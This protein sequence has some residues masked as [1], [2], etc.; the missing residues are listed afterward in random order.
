MGEDDRG[1][2]GG[3]R[4]DEE[5]PRGT[6]GAV[7]GNSRGGEEG[8][9]ECGGERTNGGMKERRGGGE[10]AMVELEREMGDKEKAAA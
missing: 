2:E 3:E 8:T 1:S 4:V 7:R 10:T 5:A 6:G 9:R